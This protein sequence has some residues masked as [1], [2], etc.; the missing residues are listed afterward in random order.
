MSSR[1]GW[2]Q[3]RRA[4]ASSLAVAAGADHSLALNEAGEVYSFGGGEQ[5]QLGHGDTACK[6]TPRTIAGLQ[7]V[8][9]RSLELEAGKDTSLAVT[10]DGD[11]YGW[12]R[13]HTDNADY[14]DEEEEGGGRGMW[15]QCSDWSSRSTSSCR[16]STRAC[17]CMPECVHPL[18][19]PP[20]AGF[21]SVQT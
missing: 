9:V 1:R 19:Q 6:L 11:A 16:S 7:G 12:E 2:L 8:R 3:R 4:Y 20:L 15:T 5:C 18:A 10:P 14:E 21:S 13:G 17:T